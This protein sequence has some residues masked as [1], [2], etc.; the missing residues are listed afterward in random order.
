MAFKL[1]RASINTCQLPMFSLL[2][3]L[4]FWVLDS[5]CALPFTFIRQSITFS[6]IFSSLLFVLDFATP[7]FLLA[8]KHIKLSN[9][10]HLT[11]RTKMRQYDLVSHIFLILSII[12]FAL[13]APVLVQEKRQACLDVVHNPEGA[14]IV[15]GERGG[16]EMELTDFL[17]NWLTKPKES[18]GS[19]PSNPDHGPTNVVDGPPPNPATSTEID[20]NDK[21]VTSGPPPPT[22]G[23]P[24]GLEMVHPSS[25]GQWSQTKLDSGHEYEAVHPLPGAVSSTE[26]EHTPRSMSAE[27]QLKNLQ[28]VGDAEKGKA[29]DLRFSGTG[30][31]STQTS[32]G[33]RLLE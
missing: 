6:D 30:L 27:S 7:F 25:W 3:T 5:A 11:H 31:L 21:L 14:I 24:K 13:A 19:A 17:D 16:Q 10:I 22:P 28:I 29:K 1:V 20:S 32:Y 18:S 15:L 8:T 2:L 33:D 26:S 4:T 12:N 23:S 9:A